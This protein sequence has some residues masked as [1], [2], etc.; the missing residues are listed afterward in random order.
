MK[1]VTYRLFFLLYISIEIVFAQSPKEQLALA[2]SVELISENFY[3]EIDFELKAGYI[4]IPIQIEEKTYHFILDTGGFNTVNSLVISEQ[5]LP[6]LMEVEVGSSNQI[7]TITKLSKIPSLEI[8]GVE[9]NNVGVFNFDFEAAPM[10]NCYTDVGLLGKSVIKE[11]VWQFD[12]QSQKITITDDLKKLPNLE[13]A[14]KLKVKFNQIYD[15]FIELKVNGQKE[16]FLLDFGFGDFMFMRQETGIKY[17]EDDVIT[18]EGEGSYGVNGPSYENSYIIHLEEIQIGEFLLENIVTLY[19]KPNN[20]NLI[21]STLIKMFIVTLNFPE[22]ELYLTPY[23]DYQDQLTESS[24]GIGLRRNVE[25]QQVYINKIYQDFLEE[26][27]DIQLHDEVIEVNGVNLE[28]LSYCDDFFYNYEI[29]NN[30]QTL[31]LTIK[32]KNE[33][34]KVKLNRVTFFK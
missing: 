1:N 17:T 21:G 7:K 26:E 34:K 31:E 4:I 19:S 15:P 11:C 32:R 30:S 25:T 23:P 10:L 28:D 16:K 5:N 8:A 24:F 3:E 6:T 9:F 33:Q 29:F 27:I 13:Q 12:L 14:S 22:K 2:N 20:Y 18:I